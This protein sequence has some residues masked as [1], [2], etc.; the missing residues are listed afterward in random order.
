MKVLYLGV[1]KDGT[2]YAKA[3]QD[4]ILALDSAGVD[5][6]PRPIKLNGSQPKIPDRILELEAKPN[7]GP[8]DA[9]I[10]HILPSFFDY[11]GYIPQNI[12]MYATETDRLPPEWVDKVNT[13]DRAWVFNESSLTA[14]HTSGVRVPVKVMPHAADVTRYQKRY[15]PLPI[16]DVIKDDFTFYFIGEYNKRKNFAALLQAFHLEFEPEEPVQLVLK[17]S[18]P[19]PIK[20]EIEAIR[21]SHEIE[22][23][24]KRLKDMMKIHASAE[25]YKK[26]IVISQSLS[27]TDI[28]R[29]HATGDCFVCPSHGEAWCIPAFDAM[30]MGKTPIVT[31]HGGFREY[32]DHFTGYLVDSTPAPVFGMENNSLP[33]MFTS[34]ERWRQVDIDHL[35]LAMRVAYNDRGNNRKVAGG[36]KRAYDFSY[37]KVGARMVE[38]LNGS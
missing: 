4:Y 13:M 15:S 23:Y 8:Y 17:F 16:K 6:V 21:F 24:I 20:D 14:S 3:A 31:D 18:C 12:G 22:N 34:R 30:A 9:V 33:G 36:I 28:M 38:K 32:I 11:N 37:E 7:R 10:Q 35:R 26:E 1:Y 19:I 2:G 27:E 29:L 25:S 5:V